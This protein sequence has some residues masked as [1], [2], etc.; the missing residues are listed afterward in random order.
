MDIEKLTELAKTS[1]RFQHQD[2]HDELAQIRADITELRSLL[3]TLL[4][5]KGILDDTF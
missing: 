1:L 3:I 5:E 2:I 4:T